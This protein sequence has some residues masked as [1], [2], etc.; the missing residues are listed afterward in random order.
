MSAPAKSYTV[1]FATGSAKLSKAANAVVDQAAAAA[2]G[3]SSTAVSV[4]GHTDTVGKPAYNQKLSVMRAA[5]VKAAL[6]K[7][8]IP[9][10]AIA[11]TGVGETG[12]AVATADNKAEQA[13][14]RVVITIK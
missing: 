5:A 14:R 13:N 9:A 4:V 11:A 2:K 10:A 1:L 8:G 12:L 3:G 7:R 6:V